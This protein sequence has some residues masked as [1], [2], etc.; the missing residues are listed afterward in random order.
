[1]RA[2]FASAAVLLLFVIFTSTR[3]E[4]FRERR[5]ELGEHARALREHVRADAMPGII[6]HAETIASFGSRQT[7]QPG[8]ERTAEYIRDELESIGLE[9]VHIE[10]SPVCVPISGE[11]SVLLSDGRRF[12]A[13]PMIPNGVQ[14]SSTGEDGMTGQ[15]VYIGKGRPGDLT[16]R[17]LHGSIVLMDYNSDANWRTAAE[18]GARAAIFIEP[19][20]TTWRQ[21]DGKYIDMV[22]LHFP[23]LWVS[24][25]VGLALKSAAEDGVEVTI[26]SEMALDN[27]DAPWV[28]GYIEGA[29]GTVATINIT[30]HFDT[31]SVVP[32]L[33]FGGDEI[34][35]VAALIETA[36]Y[37]KANPPPVNLR[38]I[39]FSGN[40][41]SHALSRVYVR[42]TLARIGTEDRLTVSID[43]STES[44]DLAVDY[45][46]LIGS[47][48]APP[49][50]DLKRIFFGEST[51]V[52]TGIAAEIRD[53]LGEDLTLYGGLKPLPHE[54]EWHLS[55]TPNKRPLTR[56]PRFYTP[57]EAWELAGGLAVV[58]QTDRLWRYTHN[59]PL[60]S[61][62]SSRARADNLTGQVEMLL[63]ALRRL[64]FIATDTDMLSIIHA[65]RWSH[66][67]GRGYAQV[68]GR[69]RVFS[70][71]TAWYAETLPTD[72]EGRPL[73]QTYVYAYPYHSAFLS[74][75]NF[76]FL[77][78]PLAPQRFFH[79]GMQS[80]MNRYIVKTEP[81]GSY[82]IPGIAATTDWAR[83]TFTAYTLDDDGRIIYATDYG[84]RGDIEYRITDARVFTHDMHVPITVFPCGSLTLFGLNC[85]H[86]HNFNQNVQDEWVITFHGGGA[87][88][89]NELAQ[90]PLLRVARV[91][92][93]GARTDAEAY[94]FAQ[95]QD[96]AMVF[97]QPDRAAEILAESPSKTVILNNST[98]PT[99]QPPGYTVS[100]GENK[101]VYFTRLEFLSQLNHL[102][103]FRLD[104]YERY[105]VRSYEAEKG[106][107]I[108]T[109]YLD[110]ANEALLERDYRKAIA[111]A[112][113]GV[114]SAARAYSSTLKL[115]WDVVSTT[116]FYFTL[117][118]PFSF[119]TE[120]L[121]VPQKT[122]SG[123]LTVSTVIFVIFVGLLWI[124][125]PGFRLADNIWI[126]IISFLIV[127]LT[128]PALAL[129]L[130][131]GVKMIKERG[132]QYYQTH[133]AEVERLG[134]LVAALSLAISNMRRRRLRTGL[135]L[136]TITLLIL[137]LVL[138]TTST[139]FQYT[140][141]E[142][143]RFIE[144]DSEGV[145]VSN[146]HDR[147]RGLFREVYH[148]LE[149]LYSDEAIV[150][151]REYFNYAFADTPAS[152]R[153]I[154][155]ESDQ[156]RVPVPSLQLLDE[157]EPKVS[158]ID[159]ALV[160][161]RWFDAEDIFSV[162]LSR[163][164]ATR[165]RVD[166]G[167]TVHFEGTPLEV[168][169]IFDGSY[170]DANIHDPD[171]KQVTPIYFADPSLGDMQ[172]PAH[173]P[174]EDI[175]Y[176]PRRLNDETRLLNTA[177]WRVVIKPF[178]R[179]RIPV[180]ADNVTLQI[181]NVD[182]FES[183]GGE[184]S[185]LSA[186]HMVS[187]QGSSFMIMPLVV[188]FFMV[189]AVMLGTVHERKRE[190]NIFS[191]V[192][193]SPRHVAGMFFVESIVYAGIASVLGYFIGIILL[194]VFRI[195]GL[196]PPVFYPNY[197]GVFVI[198]SVG[199]A[200]LATVS[201][202]IYPMYIAS[203]IANPSLERT[204]RIDTAPSNGRWQ[205]DFP[206]I[207]SDIYEVTGVMEFLRE[208]ITHFSGEGMGVFTCLE[209]PRIEMV[210][211]RHARLSF[212]A[213][214]APFERNITQA[215]SLESR[216][217]PE[218][219]R[220][221]FCFEV[222]YR[223][224]PAYLWQKSNKLFVDEFRK[225]MLIWRAFSE[226]AVEEYV[227][228]GMERHQA[229]LSL[230]H[231]D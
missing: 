139:S 60:A 130:S 138:L 36:R 144:T 184:V 168:V 44:R 100:W 155:I 58:F 20:F 213:W 165:L 187:I 26:F 23:R 170:V 196:F 161:G 112:S 50:A 83:F 154:F 63:W 128:L 185:L 116:V 149:K 72:D 114:E 90:M 219:D 109:A 96:T 227:E 224:G 129:I 147:R 10:R 208:F 86:R 87:D 231:N 24:S 32:A 106:H 59:S 153:R 68:T 40:W 22:P 204:W 202:S 186:Y 179:D 169:G 6:R 81:D 47:Y 174:A 55:E 192:G 157:R 66:A 73:G 110:I 104:S 160:S 61:F 146:T 48:S 119:L 97:L 133:S 132:E 51:R 222:T 127:I 54:S 71:A 123:T 88:N 156:G 171:G 14:P 120:R 178:D 92:V 225:Q 212:S 177:I 29:A 181:P 151:P 136:A 162:I 173:F 70:V 98:E 195:A 78:W 101:P 41:Q 206:F 145:L 197:L 25:D 214:L 37:F 210:N 124:F 103:R 11:G 189:L 62:E 164:I 12:E 134:V 17:D 8:V 38:F 199:L 107:S 80:F 85:L 31:R 176:L 190:I 64:S 99:D 43:L 115:L 56:A 35:G 13:W 191:S 126:T 220:W 193:L 217:H 69:V 53:F 89:A 141:N 121:I 19:E 84:L 77:P 5:G 102:N 1:M 150:V 188:A 52:P 9:G 167:E 45:N 108:S 137:A 21:S 140:F 166:V 94:S 143:L 57:N 105:G 215:V 163:K 142:P 180:I 4:V 201:S 117:L 211:D 42:D 148:L 125:H 172:I 15:L 203:R 91:M 194:Y 152:M 7:G 223:S 3:A 28:E 93:A 16:G 75:K 207:A 209:Q 158:G 2:R 216:K 183:V 113:L 229:Q 230:S 30:S 18:F 49:L 205:I 159:E 131:R 198:Y 118:I 122:P 135:T 221:G 228:K 111:A 175:L 182:V 67:R 74:G 76:A 79:Q 95:W 226:K 65:R 34:W 27:V 218:R 46:G 200:M 39:A 33:S 82:H